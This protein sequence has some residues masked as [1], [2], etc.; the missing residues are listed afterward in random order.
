MLVQLPNG[1]LDGADLFNYAEIDELKGKQQNYLA[2][3]ELVLGNIGH[4][5]RILEDLVISI[6][7]KEG[8]KWEGDKKDAINKLCAG[9]IETLLIKIREK[10]YGGRYYFEVACPHC[11]HINKNL[12]V[13][14]DKLE[15]DVLPL[16]KMIDKKRLT[17][18]LPKSKQE[19]ELKPLYLRDIFE[20]L[21]IVKNKQ[22]EL[23][24]SV[25]ALSIRRLGT[26]SK[27]TPADME[28]LPAMDFQ[29]LRKELETVKL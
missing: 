4:I 19:V 13:D 24:T 20:A 27:I 16:E 21:K 6:Q 10:T 12:R 5:P 1:L 23:V 18:T 14:L 9:D 2:D 8:L 7:T 3:R 15:L 22:N 26:K 28:D 17:R 29:Y 25:A 11:E